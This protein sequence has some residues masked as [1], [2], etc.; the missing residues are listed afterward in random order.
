M[1]KEIKSLKQQLEAELKNI[2][3]GHK[4]LYYK[5]EDAAAF[6]SRLD[7]FERLMIREKKEDIS[8][9]TPES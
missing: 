5:P 9:Q 4:P 2:K 8:D 1:I 7:H 3:Q 6:I